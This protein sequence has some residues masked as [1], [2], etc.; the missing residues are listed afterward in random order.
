MGLDHPLMSEA[1]QRWQGLDAE[2]IGV[3][4]RL[5]DQGP[6]VVSWWLIRAEGKEGDQRSFVQSLAVTAEGRRVPKLERPGID[7]LARF[8]RPRPSFSLKASAA[9]SCMTPSSPC[10]SES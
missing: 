9:H 3:L 1:L 8:P 6:A 2:T 7:L 4:D 5:A 10:Y